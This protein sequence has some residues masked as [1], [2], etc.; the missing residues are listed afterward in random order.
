MVGSGPERAAGVALAQTLGIADAID[1]PGF[2][3]EDEKRR[4]LAESGLFLAPSY[5]EGWGI[6]VC[7]A[8]ASRVPVVAYRL[9][10]LDELFDSSY[11]GATPGDTR[12]LAGLAAR[13]LSD[14]AFA[15]ALAERGRAAAERYDVGRVAEAE[16]AV[17]LARLRR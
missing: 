2:V 17:I 16:L 8:L 11:L 1:W 4:I 9:P 7:E 3:S 13:V 10:V 5:E 12:E 14:Q 15:A 6:S